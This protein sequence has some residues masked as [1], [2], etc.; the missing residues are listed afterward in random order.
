MI[1]KQRKIQSPHF[2]GFAKIYPSEQT[3]SIFELKCK[4]QTFS[5]RF[6]L[7]YSTMN[8]KIIISPYSYPDT[9]L[10]NTK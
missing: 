3:L 8:Q 5:V 1:K 7:F 2:L 10:K 4:K 9:I 6:V